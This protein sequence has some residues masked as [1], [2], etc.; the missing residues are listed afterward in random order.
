MGPP[1]LYV[2]TTPVG[3]RN[4][5]KLGR[6]IAAEAAVVSINVAAPSTHLLFSP[7][8]DEL[9]FIHMSFACFLVNDLLAVG[10]NT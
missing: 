1:E 5:N 7:L 9:R 2:A 8:L 3:S 4:G 6:R 10:T